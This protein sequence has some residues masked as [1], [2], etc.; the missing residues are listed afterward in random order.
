MAEVH[1]WQVED[2]RGNSIDVSILVNDDGGPDE[3]EIN[4]DDLVRRLTPK[5][6]R[7]LACDLNAAARIALKK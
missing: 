2:V 5:V 4:F 7:S 3:I 6:A 1:A